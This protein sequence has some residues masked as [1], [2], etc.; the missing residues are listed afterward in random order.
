MFGLQFRVQIPSLSLSLSL[1]ESP[2]LSRMKWSES[3]DTEPSRGAGTLDN[4][5]IYHYRLQ[6]KCGVNEGLTLFSVASRKTEC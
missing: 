4:T 2:L 3:T 5:P 1:D 6:I